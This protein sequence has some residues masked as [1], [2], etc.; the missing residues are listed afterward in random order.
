[1]VKVTKQYLIMTA[2][3][4]ILLLL[5]VPKLIW[6]MFV[7]HTF[8]AIFKTYYNNY[9]PDLFTIRVRLHMLGAIYCIH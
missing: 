5:S 1:M 6:R 4:C 7:D 9:D 2:C 8:L 3:D